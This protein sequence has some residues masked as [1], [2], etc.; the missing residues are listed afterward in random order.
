MGAVWLPRLTFLTETCTSGR[1]DSEGGRIS[2]FLCREVRIAI[3][4]LEGGA[5]V[6][7]HGGGVRPVEEYVEYDSDGRRGVA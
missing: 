2:G 5:W 4:R 1:F 7:E 6:G 3:S